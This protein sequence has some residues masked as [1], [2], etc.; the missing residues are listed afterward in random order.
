MV[1]F[2]YHYTFFCAKFTLVNYIS[3][4]F[5]LIAV[6]LLAVI[7]MSS[8]GVLSAD[9]EFGV[10]IIVMSYVA[11]IL[12]SFLFCHPYPFPG[13]L[14]RLSEQLKNSPRPFYAASRH[15][16]EGSFERDRTVK[17]ALAEFDQA[18][19]DGQYLTCRLALSKIPEHYRE[20][21]AVQER[22]AQLREALERQ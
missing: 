14:L 13:L 11:V 12:A 7:K 16:L 22:E 1:A 6:I 3:A 19:K 5:L 4:G 15:Y 2:Q 9:N 18:L 8:E 17:P 21:G 20:V 10:V